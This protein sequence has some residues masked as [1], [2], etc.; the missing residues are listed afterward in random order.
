MSHVSY[1]MSWNDTVTDQCAKTSVVPMCTMQPETVEGDVTCSD[2]PGTQ[3]G[4]PVCPTQVTVSIL[5]SLTRTTLCSIDL[6]PYI[7]S[8]INGCL[9]GHTDPMLPRLYLAP[10]KLNDASIIND[11]TQVSVGQNIILIYNVKVTKRD[12]TNKSSQPK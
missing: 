3:P 7:Q 1:F 9:S 11:N 8:Q 4:S 12:K 2:Y 5:T 6:P 10:S